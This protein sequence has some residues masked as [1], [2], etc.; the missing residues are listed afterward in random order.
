MNHR[1]P[2]PPLS[3]ARS[4]RL[5]L[6]ADHVVCHASSLPLTTPSHP[7]H[8][9][10]PGDRATARALALTAATV[11]PTGSGHA[12]GHHA[13]PVTPVVLTFPRPRRPLTQ[14]SAATSGRRPPLLPAPSPR[15]V[16]A[17]AVAPRPCPCRPPA[18][19]NSPHLP[20]SAPP[21]Q[22]APAPPLS[23]CRCPTP[24]PCSA[25]SAPARVGRQHAPRP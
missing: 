2:A 11:P 1:E 8:A 18:P 20:A 16:A 12:R 10:A 23:W 17:A 7:P 24:A 19:P 9:P 14:F 3:L 5:S 21:R 22:A 13:V 4:R 25:R 6:H 15:A